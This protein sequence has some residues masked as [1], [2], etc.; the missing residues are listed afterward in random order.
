MPCYMFCATSTVPL[1]LLLVGLRGW[2]RHSLFLSCACCNQPFLLGQ[3]LGNPYWW[4]VCIIWNVGWNFSIFIV[5]PH[6][7][8]LGSH[9]QVSLPLDHIVCYNVI[10]S[11]TYTLRTQTH[12]HRISPLLITITIPSSHPFLFPP[13]ALVGPWLTRIHTF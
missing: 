12:M 9:S 2:L 4:F 3:T 11:F 13:A 1:S 6:W 5:H 7:D 10:T 8:A